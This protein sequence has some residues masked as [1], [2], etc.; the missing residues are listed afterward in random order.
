MSVVDRNFLTDGTGRA[1]AEALGEVAEAIENG[2]GG[3]GTTVTPNPQG[4]PTD[5][6]ETIQ[7]GNTIYDIPGSGS[8]G[9]GV[10]IVQVTQTEADSSLATADKTYAEVMTAIQSGKQ[11][12]AVFN[13]HEGSYHYPTFNTLTLS[14]YNNEA[15]DFYQA[16][17]GDDVVYCTSATIMAN[18]YVFVHAASISANSSY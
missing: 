15:I 6:L 2:G 3:G 16:D 7:I 8:S 18:G 17:I 11:V 9:G 10:L 12:Y 4:E 1:I 14:A 5:D 13:H